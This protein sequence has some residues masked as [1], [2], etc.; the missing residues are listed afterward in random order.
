MERKVVFSSISKEEENYLFNHRTQMW[1]I[2]D[3]DNKTVC[4]ITPPD[5]SFEEQ[6]K[7]ANG[8]IMVNVAVNETG[9]IKGTWENGKFLPPTF[10]DWRA[11]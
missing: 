3:L 10:G 6:L 9:W 8:R 1:A 2:L 11:I 5:I 4:G 7:L